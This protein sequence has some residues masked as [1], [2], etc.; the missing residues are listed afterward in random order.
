MG[1]NPILLTIELDPSITRPPVSW[2]MSDRESASLSVS[3]D[4]MSC[5]FSAL[6]PSG[7]NE[8]TIS[9]YG[10]EVLFPVY[11]WER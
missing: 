6:K 7:K 9:C 4:R 2:N 1:D 11:L 5:E 8:L 10:T 3:E